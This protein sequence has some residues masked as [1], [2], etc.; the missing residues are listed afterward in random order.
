MRSFPIFGRHDLMGEAEIFELN[1]APMM[2]RFYAA[3][4]AISR[5]QYFM[6]H[7]RWASHGSPLDCRYDFFSPAARFYLAIRW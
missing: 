5:L 1:A 2:A 4:A 6:L 3:D 7:F